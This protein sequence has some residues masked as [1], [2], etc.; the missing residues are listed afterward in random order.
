MATVELT[1]ENFRQLVAATELLLVEFWA[2][3]CEP[4]TRFAPVFEAASERHPGALFGRVNV[5][6]EQELAAAFRITSI[7]YVL[8]LREQVIVFAQAGALP[9]EG[10]DSVLAQ[11]R[12]LDMRRVREEIAQRRSAEASGA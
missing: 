6:E 12:A 9:A 1:R 2:P 11:V 7:P 10:L 8:A 3:W 4:C 5:D